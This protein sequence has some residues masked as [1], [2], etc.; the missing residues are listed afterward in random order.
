MVQP[1]LPIIIPEV[2]PDQIG[3]KA[4]D[5]RWDVCVRGKQGPSPG[6]FPGLIEGQ[7]VFFH[8]HPDPFYSQE[9]R[10]PFVH[11]VDRGMDA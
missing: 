1:Q 10:V 4:V 9:R 5:P 2:T 7:T 11:M 8:K 3:G 6:Q